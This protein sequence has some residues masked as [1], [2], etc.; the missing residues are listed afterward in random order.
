MIAFYTL[1]L[2]ILAR[3]LLLSFFNTDL[4]NFIFNIARFTFAWSTSVCLVIWSTF[5]T[6]LLILLFTHVY[7]ILASIWFKCIILDV[8][9][10][11]SALLTFFVFYT[12]SGITKL[13]LIGGY[14]S[15]SIRLCWIRCPFC[16]VQFTIWI[17]LEFNTEVVCHILLSMFA[18]LAHRR[19]IVFI[20]ITIRIFWTA[21]EFINYA[22]A[23]VTFK[24]GSKLILITALCIFTIGN[25]RFR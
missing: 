19:V 3:T 4:I 15:P 8:Y 13:T 6:Y 22:L 17:W 24:T 14:L 16:F 18:L 21:N 25:F 12:V 2:F 7:F 10:I 1:S 5:C 20:F 23:F 9:L 11:F